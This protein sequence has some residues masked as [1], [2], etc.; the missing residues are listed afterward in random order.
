VYAAVK[1]MTSEDVGADRGFQAAK[2]HL[3]PF[4]VRPKIDAEPLSYQQASP[5][6]LAAINLPRLGNISSIMRAVGARNTTF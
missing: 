4:W 1:I 3:P 5:K 2:L 6:T